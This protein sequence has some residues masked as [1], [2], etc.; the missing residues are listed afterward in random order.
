MI[1]LLDRWFKRGYRK[2]W[3]C[4]NYLGY[5]GITRHKR[6]EKGKEYHV[7]SP[8]TNF[9]MEDAKGVQPAE[10]VRE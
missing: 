7:L 5:R 8:L 6:K 1:L 9:N 4:L 10:G 3:L 2:D